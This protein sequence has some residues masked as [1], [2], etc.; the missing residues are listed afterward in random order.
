ARS[1]GPRDDRAP[2]EQRVRRGPD[3]GEARPRAGGR[4]RGADL[5]SEP[6]VLRASSLSKS[7]PQPGGAA[8]GLEGVDLELGAGEFV[9]ILGPSGSGKSTLL[10][11]LGLMDAPTS[12]VLE[13]YGRSVVGMNE[14]EQSA[15]RNS[16]LGFVFQFDSLL[17]EFTLL[18][19]A[20]MPG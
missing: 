11:L 8:K 16:R 20:A 13:L 6:L 5:M 19:N 12:G 1:P 2:A 18:E 3:G 4:H 15:V 7:Y 17:P 14:A 10:H 9:A